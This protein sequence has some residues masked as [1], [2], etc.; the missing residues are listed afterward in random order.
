MLAYT[1][2][3]HLAKN[4]A[5]T[6]Q[7]AGL[8]PAAPGPTRER[9]PKLPSPPGPQ[10]HSR[11]SQA[12]RPGPSAS[13][14]RRGRSQRGGGGG[15]RRERPGRVGPA[16]ES[17]LPLAE[18]EGGAGPFV[19]GLRPQ[20]KGRPPGVGTK[21]RSGRSRGA[22]QVPERRGAGAGGR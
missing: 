11:R 21:G 2:C 19:R 7:R 5:K 18:A 4:K 3:A 10:S 15:G 17:R 16:G 20:R 22:D 13:P 6:R 14:G 1:D 8:N 9:P 12:A